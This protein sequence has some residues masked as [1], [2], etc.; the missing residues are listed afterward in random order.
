M[1]ELRKVNL[2]CIM[3]KAKNIVGLIKEIAYGI[4]IGCCVRYDLES[5]EYLELHQHR[6]DE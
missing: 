6:L 1:A 5:L 3:D 2:K 4:S